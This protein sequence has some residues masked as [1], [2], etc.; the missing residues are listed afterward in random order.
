VS[1]IYESEMIQG[2]T[3]PIWH[4]AVPNIS[5]GLVVGSEE[6]TPFTCTLVL[7]EV[8]RAITDMNIAR[9]RFLVQITSDESNA[10]NVG[11][12]RIV[13]QIKNTNISPAYRS[14]VQIDLTVKSQRYSE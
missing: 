13:V 10:L 12:N 8:T 2:D 7:G 11:K 3:G 14:E 5:D 9:D 4:I 6:L 1:E